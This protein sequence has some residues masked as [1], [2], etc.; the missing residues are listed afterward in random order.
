MPHAE[1]LRE[2]DP[3]I[4]GPYWLLGRLGAGGQG[5]VY[6]ARGRAGALVAVKVLR[7]GAP[8]SAWPR[9]STRR[10]G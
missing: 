3:A 6:L 7:D 4:V 1:R 2:G 9:R 5:I 10:G 8:T